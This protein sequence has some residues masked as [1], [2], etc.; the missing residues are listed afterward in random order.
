MKNN[1][2]FSIVGCT[3]KRKKKDIHSG[4]RIQMNLK[5]YQLADII[6]IFQKCPISSFTF[7]YKN[8]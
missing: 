8:S 5:T 6:C 7:V 2:L 3:K 4:V 1:S